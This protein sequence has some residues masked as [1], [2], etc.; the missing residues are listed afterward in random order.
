MTLLLTKEAS[1][2]IHTVNRYLSQ[3]MTVRLTTKQ[4][5]KLQ[6]ACE[7]LMSNTPCNQQ[8]YYEDETVHGDQYHVEIGFTEISCTRSYEDFQMCISKLQF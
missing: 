4:A 8:W 2:V 7:I 1:F 5:E 3:F 6:K